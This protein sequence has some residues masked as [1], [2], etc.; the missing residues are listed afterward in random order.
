MAQTLKFPASMDVE[1][2][3]FIIDEIIAPATGASGAAVACWL[4][5]GDILW[6]AAATGTVTLAG[7]E[8]V[9]I[10]FPDS[11]G[12]ASGVTLSDSSGAVVLTA[13]HTLPSWQPTFS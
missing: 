3:G 9:D 6:A 7:A 2:H 12:I 4:S 13:T 5:R 8:E 10:Y 11:T 1:S